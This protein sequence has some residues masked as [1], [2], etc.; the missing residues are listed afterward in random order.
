MKGSVAIAAI[1]ALTVLC[2]L[3]EEET[4]Q[5]SRRPVFSGSVNLMVASGYLATSGAIYDTMPITT[6]MLYGKADFGEWGYIDGYGWFIS[7]LH[8]RQND[9][10]RPLLH[11]FE[12][13]L[14]YGYKYN[15]TDLVHVN[16]KAG[17]LW[18]PP[19]GY[20]GSHQNYWGPY[21]SQ[22][23]ENPYIVP[24]WSGFWLL[25][26]QRRG[27]IRMGLRKSFAP[28]EHV[29]ITPFAETVWM[30]RRRFNTRYGGDPEK[31]HFFG[32]TFA[33]VTTGAKATW[34]FSD[35]WKLYA[36]LMQFD[37]VNTQARRSVKRSDA[38]YAKCDWPIIRV[39]V[40]Y[41]F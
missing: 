24:Y 16:T 25:E 6:Q 4:M 38:Y 10:H 33:T 31:D 37:I 29:S 1:G 14:C 22:S 20:H 13:T 15:V 23:M 7:S 28:Y 19:I 30:D 3:A 17:P 18:N 11:E 8:N 27:R 32:G 12:G 39:G 26:P 2:A 5:Q 40:E 35:G 21:I 36:T 9:K 34:T 41:D